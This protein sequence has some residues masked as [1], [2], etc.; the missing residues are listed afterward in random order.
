MI[1]RNP[2]KIHAHKNKP[3]ELSNTVKLTTF[4]IDRYYV[5]ISLFQNYWSTVRIPIHDNGSLSN[6][7]RSVD[8]R[9]I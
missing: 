8:F 7:E 3:A 1:K 6:I 4:K 2:Q 5:D 9:V